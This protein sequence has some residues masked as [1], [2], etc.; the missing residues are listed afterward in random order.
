MKGFDHLDETSAVSE[1]E[2][3]EGVESGDFKTLGVNLTSKENSPVDAGAEPPAAPE[4][5]PKGLPAGGPGV[6]VHAG[7]RHHSAAGRPH[8]TA[9]PPHIFWHSTELLENSLYVL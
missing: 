1:T 5:V 4:V 8:E 9:L 6:P 3:C 7:A 2:T